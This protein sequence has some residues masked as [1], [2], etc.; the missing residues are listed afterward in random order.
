MR[1]RRCFRSASTSPPARW[2]ASRASTIGVCIWPGT[3]VFTRIPL[4]AYWTATTR[5]NWM[6]AAFDAA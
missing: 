1:A 4:A 3:T 2:P 5:E 6:T